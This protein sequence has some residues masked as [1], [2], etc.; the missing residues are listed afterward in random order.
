MAGHAM[1]L[2]AAPGESRER[3]LTVAAA[4]VRRGEIIVMPTEHVYALA[5]DAFVG[6]DALRHAKGQD[7]H[8]SLPI[9]V[10][11][12]QMVAGIAQVRPLASDLM[13]ALWPGELTLVLPAQSTLAWSA[14]AG[15][16][17]AVRMPIHPCALALVQRTG[18]LAVSAAVAPPAPP[19]TRAEEAAEPFGEVVRAVIDVG[20]LTGVGVSTVLDLTAEV[21]TI[22]REGAVEAE[23]LRSLCPN[24]VIAP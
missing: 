23:Q 24:L 21:P 4:A 8:V 5:A 15:G 16:S 13:A 19:P 3:A 7:S 22:R 1:N 14:S 9:F 12:A 11:S 2:N 17:V 6:A 18:P 10:A 20:P